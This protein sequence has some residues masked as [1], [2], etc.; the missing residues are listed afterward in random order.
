MTITSIN[1]QND[2]SSTSRPHFFN[3]NDYAYYKARI[4]TYLII[5]GYLLRI[6]LT[7][8]LKPNMVL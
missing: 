5:Y 6:D 7:N 3:G 2:G 8:I 1:A 4:I